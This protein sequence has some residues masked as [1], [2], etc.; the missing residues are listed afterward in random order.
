[1]LKSMAPN[2][3]KIVFY[4]DDDDDGECG[5]EMDIG[6]CLFFSNYS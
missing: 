3:C 2:F 4:H 5:G 6:V 1:M